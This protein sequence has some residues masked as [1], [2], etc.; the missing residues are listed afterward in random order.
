MLRGPGGAVLGVEHHLSELNFRIL[1]EVEVSSGDRLIPITSARQRIVLA[2]LL[3]APNHVVP[4]ER[5][6]ESVWEDNPPSTARG[7]IQICVSGLRR[8]L[9]DPQVISTTSSGYSINAAP[10]QLD[11]IQFDRML[12]KARAAEAEGRLA[13]AIGQLDAALGLWRGSALTGVPGLAAETMAHRLEERRIM[14]LENKISIQLTLGV[15]QD[16]IDDLL[17]ITA[18]HPLRERPYGFLMLALYRSGRQAEALTV[19]RRARKILVDELGLEPGEALR[20]LERA[21]LSHDTSLDLAE[22]AE[23]EPP[24]RSARPPRQLPATVPG[25]V[26]RTAEVAEL[27]AVLAPANADESDSPDIPIAV[28]TGQPGC[29]KS[30][31]VLHAAHQL[32]DRFPNGQLYAEMRG[33][34]AQRA[35]P[36]DVLGRFLRALGVPAPDVPLDPDE[37]VSMFR[38][39]VAFRKIL[40]VLD[41]AADEEQ[42][43]A[44]LPGSPG[45]AVLVS[46]RSRLPALLG[47]HVV[48]PGLLPD[49]DA[50]RLLELTAGKAR[51]AGDRAAV[52]KLVNLC[53]GLP[54]AIRIAGVRLAAH[55]HWTVGTLVSRLADQQHRLDELSHGGVG[56]RPLLSMVYESLSPDGRRLFR[57]LGTLE[58][59]DIIPLVAAAAL[60]RG[61]GEAARRLD[62]LA[63][64]R[65][66]DVQPESDGQSARYF[67]PDLV[68]VFAVECAEQA[69][70][71][72]RDAPG[73]PDQQCE[74]A[75]DRDAVGRVLSRVLTVASEAYRRI[76][77]GDYT[78]LRGGAPQ[79]A[80]PETELAQLL[81]D[82]LAWLDAQRPIIRTAISQA[83][84]LG[85]DEYCWELAV[86]AVAVY[87]AYGLFDEWRDTHLEALRATRAAGNR[88][89]QAAVL[90]SLGSLGVAQHSKDDVDMLLEALALFE[91]VGDQIGQAMALR[92][93]AHLDRIQGRAAVAV[94]RYERALGA[95]RDTGDVVA[96]AH[97]LSGLGRAYLDLGQPERAAVLAAESLELAENLGNRRLQS[98]A[99][100]RLGEIHLRA[101]SG[102]LA[103]KAAFERS[104]ELTRALGDKVGESYSLCGLGQAAL[105]LGELDSAEIHLNEAVKICRTANERNVQAQAVFGLGRVHEERQEH[106]NAELYY[107]RAANAFARQENG[108][109]HART[110]AALERVRE[111]AGQLPS[112][113]RGEE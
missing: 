50:T 107:V 60:D 7:Q 109:W 106:E 51:V 111:V 73:A 97:V 30:A 22:T 5:L 9:G 66:L 89:G 113:F 78:W 90:V 42:I 16:L 48:D 2:C 68:R 96:Q 71:A 29:G 41:D 100:Y 86:T 80:A 54:V 31:L 72:G 12:A 82:P 75:T 52:E 59:H 101:P 6:I 103:A 11:Y 19:Y 21:I 40:L 77:G 95:F 10:D 58:L 69:A 55:Q 53:G 98:Q 63:T 1:G 24:N 47:A 33:S 32:R 91:E 83:A 39:L 4:V 37:R 36:M 79:W 87:E 45:P 92:N 70:A 44:L 81:D 43:A 108:P 8:L 13:E 93:L 110:V 65:L 14:T 57:L 88:R 61:L 76:Y 102:K 46:S 35:S 74:S 94:Q 28:V 23:L 15:H 26:G 56:V 64:V 49:A 18:D 62:E 17:T 85:L 104:L 20:D 67:F 112:I 3:M 105:E 84:R 27:A 38:S 25:F 99:L 34:T